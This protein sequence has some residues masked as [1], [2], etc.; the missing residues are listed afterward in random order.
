MNENL[1]SHGFLAG[2]SSSYN[3]Y[4]KVTDTSVKDEDGEVTELKINTTYG[5]MQLNSGIVT[6]PASEI[7]V[8]ESDKF[9]ILRSSLLQTVIV[10]SDV[11]EY[12]EGESNIVIASFNVVDG[13]ITD[14]VQ[15]NYGQPLGIILGKC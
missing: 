1:A 13:L 10:S 4:F 14:L 7:S 6:V 2:D 11:F 9:I 5:I 12:T 3:G 15:Q 8:R